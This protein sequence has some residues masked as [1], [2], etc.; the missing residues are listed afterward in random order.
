MDK[1]KRNKAREKI[2]DILKYTATIMFFFMSLYLFFIAFIFKYNIGQ[3]Y[4]L[5]SKKLVNLVSIA[6][7][8]VLLFLVT[9]VFLKMK[10]HK[11]VLSY[12]SLGIV[13][14]LAGILSFSYVNNTLIFLGSDSKA[15]MVLAEMFY[16]SD[17]SAVVPKDSYLSLWPFQCSYI[18]ILEKIMRLFKDTSVLL[19]QRINCV[20]WLIIIAASFRIVCKTCQNYAFRIFYLIFIVTY[21]PLFFYLVNVYGNLPGFAFLLVGSMLYFEFIDEKNKKAV[22]ITA[23]VLFPISLIVSCAF[24]STGLIFII[25]LAI[26]TVLRQIKKTDIKE[27]VI[28]A[29]TIIVC[30]NITSICQKYY[31]HYANNTCGDGVPAISYI[32]MGIQHNEDY[33]KWGGWNGFHSNTYMENDYNR[34]ITV[35]ISKKAIGESIKE[36]TQNPLLIID[37][38][39]K[40]TSSQWANPSHEIF[41]GLYNSWDVNREQ[42]FWTD[43]IMNK[44]YCK[45]EDYMDVVES[46][47]YLY[48]FIFAIE[49]LIKVI[50]KKSIDD[51]DALIMVASIGGFLFSIIWEAHG[52]YTMNYLILMLPLGLRS[53]ESLFAKILRGLSH[54][55]NVVGR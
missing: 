15:C 33:S 39:Y 26:V 55:D 4:M 51:Y 19:F 9:K 25:A 52:P 47:A 41:W 46:I 34:E 8:S 5:Q 11:E 40:K 53:T 12:L 16:N 17:F 13:L 28:V 35:E 18:L 22:R 14:V 36:F 38:L 2:S 27:I 43:Y 45:L 7:C 30:V 54:E 10:K 31:E 3:E 1:T 21:F 42:S 20:Y 23:A 44:E 49:Q 48:I 32:A 29:L 37:F 24:K 50:K 6:L